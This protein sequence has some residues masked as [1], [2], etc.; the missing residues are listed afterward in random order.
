MTYMVLAATKY[1][2]LTLIGSI[3]HFWYILVQPDAARAHNLSQQFQIVGVLAGVF[4]RISIM[5]FI[6]LN[7]T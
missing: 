1:I 3:N 7:S 5:Q 2:I 4:V 6:A